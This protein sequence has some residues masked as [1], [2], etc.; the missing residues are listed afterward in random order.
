MR[1][2]HAMYV[3]SASSLRSRLTGKMGERAHDKRNN[4]GLALVT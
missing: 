2:L 1:P 3:D 4:T